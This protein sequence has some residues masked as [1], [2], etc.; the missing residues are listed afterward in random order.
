[1]DITHAFTDERF[2]QYVLDHFCNQRDSIQESDIQEVTSLQLTSQDVRSLSG[3]EYFRDLEELDCSYNQITY[4]DLGRN[5]KLRI[6]H[7]KENQILSLDLSSNTELER[8]DCSFNRLRQLDVSHNPK[9]IHLECHWN[10]LSQLDLDKQ[11]ELEELGCSYNA[12][13]SLE[14]HH[15]TL[16][17]QLNCA[18]NYLTSVDLTNCRALI[19][20]RCHD[21]HIKELDLRS[22]P[23]LESVR[24]FN[25]HISKLDIQHNTQLRELYCSEN[26]LT[27]LDRSHNSK[28]EKLHTVDNLMTEFAHAVQGMGVFQYNGS[29]SNYQL[30]L[31]IQGGGEL[32]VTAQVSTKAEMEELTP[33]MEEAWRRWQSLAE[34][35]LVFIAEA[36]PDEDVS[37]LVLAD[38]EFQ[39]CEVFRL[40]YDAGDTP[41]GRMYIYAEFDENLQLSEQL[42]YEMY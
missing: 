26:K 20:L 31:P 30:N 42:I 34:Q 21:N 36:H 38:V 19:E 10:M 12:L 28:L 33:Y 7:C 22:N 39:D 27:E 40:G 4:V 37:E 3:I 6:L 17:K 29:F 16:L 18:S 41:A 32:V 1:M 13:F 5:N 14:L 25:N 11:V 15:N 35:A 8:M 9:L 2:R 24:C 23:K